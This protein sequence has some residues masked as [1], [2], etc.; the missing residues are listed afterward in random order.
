MCYIFQ[1][2]IAGVYI[3]I[4]LAAFRSSLVRRR[5]YCRIFITL[6]G[7]G[8][9]ADFLGFCINGFGIGTLHYISSRSDFDF[10][11]AE[12]FV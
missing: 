12:I 5:G 3:L 8:N 7:H 9:E 11:F 2:F 6:K 4:V 10:E 1:Y